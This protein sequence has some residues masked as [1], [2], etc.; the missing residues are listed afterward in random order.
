MDGEDILLHVKEGLS[1]KFAITEEF[2]QRHEQF[3]ASL[4]AIPALTGLQ[5]KV[6]SK[7]FKDEH[8]RALSEWKQ[9]WDY[10]IRKSNFNQKLHLFL[11]SKEID[12][13]KI[14]AVYKSS[15]ENLRV[16]SDEDENHSP[17]HASDK[18]PHTSN[19]PSAANIT[20]TEMKW[21][22]EWLFGSDGFYSV[23]QAEEPKEILLRF[24]KRVYHMEWDREIKKQSRLLPKLEGQMFEVE[25]MWKSEHFFIYANWLIDVFICYTGWNDPHDE[26]KLPE[27]SKWMRLMDQARANAEYLCDE[28]ALR[29]ISEYITVVAHILHQRNPSVFEHQGICKLIELEHHE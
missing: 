17:T 5:S 15:E 19:E 29:K 10:M 18:K 7:G 2:R 24:A 9:I 23:R 6:S 26:K 14:N 21:V 25:E 27:L 8:G 16:G 20:T 13:M 1:A 28:Q 11:R 12:P 22:L 3:V 4:R